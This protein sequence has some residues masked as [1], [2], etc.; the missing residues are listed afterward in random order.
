MST[1]SRIDAESHKSPEA[2]EREI[3]QQRA[4][5]GNIVDALENKLSPGQWVD[6]ALKYSKDN[7]GEFITNLGVTLKNNPVPT[8]LTSIGLAWL[9]LGQNRPPRPTYAMG[10]FGGGVG[11]GLRDAAQGVKGTVRH[12]VDAVAGAV[13]SAK[14]TVQHGRDVAS[15]KADHLSEEF[16][17]V[18][19]TVSDRSHQAVDA[20]R[21]QAD[22]LRG[23]FDYLLR[24]QPLAV[25]AMGIALGALLG[26]ALPATSQENRLM[27]EA[28]DHL[29]D[30]AKRLAQQG[31]EKVAEAGKSAVEEF[32]ESG[33]GQ[34][35]SAN[36]GVGA[37]ADTQPGSGDR[38]GLA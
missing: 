34:A 26:S 1:Q 36:Q 2:L 35:G 21:H 19:Q 4:N 7:G 33:G 20:L 30:E 16:G 29:A 9:M 11:S 6:Q 31:Y 10:E 8:V 14:E 3:D 22:S 12:A 23:G 5:I 37:D 28:S 15:E 17:S 24:E 38:S 32:K 27:G 18:R 13:D 25:A